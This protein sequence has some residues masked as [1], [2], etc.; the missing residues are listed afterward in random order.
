MEHDYHFY[1]KGECLDCCLEVLAA[2]RSADH[3]LGAENVVEEL[4]EDHR[5][6]V[7]LYLLGLVAAA[8]PIGSSRRSVPDL[9]L[10]MSGLKS[11]ARIASALPTP[12]AVAVGVAE[13]VRQLVPGRP[14]FLV[15]KVLETL[16]P[17]VEEELAALWCDVTLLSAERYP[18]EAGGLRARIEKR[19][20]RR[21]TLWANSLDWLLAIG[22]HVSDLDVSLTLA[23]A[24][25]H[26][27]VRRSLKASVRSDMLEVRRRAEGIQALADGSGPIEQRLLDVLAGSLDAR[28]RV[29]PRPL[30]APSSTWLASNNLEDLTRGAVSAAVADFMEFVSRSG[31]QEEES[32]T[33]RLLEKLVQNFSIGSKMGR[34]ATPESP[35]VALASRQETKKVEK[36]NG[37]DIGILLEV[38]AP[39]RL[40]TR[41]GDLVQVKKADALIPSASRRDAWKI[42]RLQLNTLLEHSPTAS[43]W[44]IPNSGKVCVVPAKFL[45]AIGAANQRRASLF[46]VGH[47]DIRHVAVGLDNYL[48]DLI[49]G[50][51]LGSSS[52]AALAAAAGE[53]PMNRP[54]FFL[55]IKVTLPPLLD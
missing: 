45:A 12:S 7:E 54:E 19:A 47:S 49:V 8:L 27:S 46:T 31:A 5:S 38:E 11:P 34:W 24:E 2:G 40:T 42:N 36:T 21:P 22:P 44:L 13:A 6:L 28:R 10:W 51:W 23:L 39:D 1:P 14:D 17:H 50:M 25:Q 15:R 53:T 20:S 16:A 9:V 52:E 35:E 55:N 29:F 4:V 33:A 30:E 48:T 3:K 43:Y 18:V 26:R 41:I 37:A 32:L